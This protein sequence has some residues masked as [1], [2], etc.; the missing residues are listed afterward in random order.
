MNARVGEGGTALPGGPL[1]YLRRGEEVAAVLEPVRKAVQAAQP[2]HL[3]RNADRGGLGEE[4]LAR[5]VE[6]LREALRTAC[7]PGATSD[8]SSAPAAG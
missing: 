7:C 8:R 6:Q 2:H 4:A 5:L 1:Q 3:L